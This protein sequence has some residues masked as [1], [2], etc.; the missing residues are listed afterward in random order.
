MGVG[1]FETLYEGL[2][3]RVLDLLP[4]SMW[5]W[6]FSMGSV[7]SWPYYP[8]PCGS[9]RFPWVLSGLGL[10]TPVH[11]A[12]AVL[13]GFRRVFDLLPRSMWQWPFVRWLGMQEPA[14]AIFSL[15]NLIGHAL[16][17]RRFTCLVPRHAPLYWLWVA[18]SLVSPGRL[19]WNPSTG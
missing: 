13:N 19:V 12:V 4:R 2:F 17:L 8:G 3:C 16:M 7:G 14:S 11:V 15:L 6:P 9:G 5:Q 1:V 10:T 18:Y